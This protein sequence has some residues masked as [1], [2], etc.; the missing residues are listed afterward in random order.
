MAYASLRLADQHLPLRNFA[1]NHYCDESG[2]ICTI[3]YDIQLACNYTGCNCALDHPAPSGMDSFCT[4]GV[5]VHSPVGFFV[6]ASALV[7]HFFF[8]QALDYCPVC[9]FATHFVSARSGNH[10]TLQMPGSSQFV[11]RLPVSRGVTCSVTK[12]PP[13]EKSPI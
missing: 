2:E 1:T 7:G 3:S 10:A 13:K 11:F 9:L 4:A 5:S 8:I 6:P 12:W